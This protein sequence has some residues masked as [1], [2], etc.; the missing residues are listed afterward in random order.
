MRYGAGVD[1]EIQ[2][3]REGAG[4]LDM[5][6][7][8]SV[9]LSGPDARRFCNGMFT[10]NI[11]D[12]K[13]GEGNRS[14]ACDDLGR[15]HCLL[16]IY[17]TDPHTFLAV[18]EGVDSGW[19]EERYGLY[20]VF[21]DVEMIA[22][23]DD[24]WVLSVQGPKATDVLAAAGLPAPSSGHAQV[25]EGIRVCRK[26]RAGTGGFD[27]FV[28]ADVLDTTFEALAASGASP[29]GRE[30]LE[31]VRIAHGRAAWPQDGTEKSLVHELGLD[32]EVC[33]FTKGCYLGQEVINRVD[34]KGQ[35]NKRLTGLLLSED[36][37]P[38]GGAQVLLGEDVVGAVT[39][40]A[41]VGTQAMA[42]GVLRKAAWPTDTEVVIQ[43]GGKTVGAQV[44]DLPFSLK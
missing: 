29:V 35:V 44:V 30:A 39:S 41:R 26:D 9:T 21:D 16:D 24:P 34:V 1:E 40:A 23:P 6:E 22:H 33:S 4:L 31:A 27:L 32:K 13:P 28:P 2:S 37:L 42:L 17:C 38:P 8:Q 36:A 19:F 15:I 3:L 11:R 5:A 10:N 25:G 12:L 7:V 20:I 14:A 18:L 43:A